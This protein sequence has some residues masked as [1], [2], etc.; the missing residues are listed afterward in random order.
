MI[1]G[2][3]CSGVFNITL[4]VGIKADLFERRQQRP[5]GPAAFPR[6]EDV[7]GCS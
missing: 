6:F 2:A 1:S 3:C 4:Q 7:A 5:A